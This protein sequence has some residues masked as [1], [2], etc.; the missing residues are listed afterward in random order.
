MHIF[1]SLIG[2]K[3]CSIRWL[4]YGATTYRNVTVAV[5]PKEPRQEELLLANVAVDAML[6]DDT[7]TKW[8]IIK[9]FF[10]VVVA[11]LGK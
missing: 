8:G 7:L 5:A 9:L 11:T 10:V 3:I 6:V 4:C 1:L 2:Y